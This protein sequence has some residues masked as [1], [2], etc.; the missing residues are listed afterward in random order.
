MDN[1]A[2]LAPFEEIAIIGMTGRFPLARNVDELWRNLRDGVESVVQFTD[3]ELLAAGVDPAL[4]GDPNYV[5]AGT[6][7]EGPDLFDAAFFGFNPRETEI[8]DPQQRLFLECAHESLELAGYDPQ[9]YRGLIGVF[10]GASASSYLANNLNKNPGVL[11]SVSP[12]QVLI[13]TDKDFVP[14]RV[15]YKLNLRGPS[16]N[17]QTACST[18]LVAVHLACQSLLERACDIALAG[19]VSIHFPLRAGYSYEEEGILSPDGHCRAFDIQARGCVGGNGVAIVVLKRLSEA[20]ADGDRILASIKGSAINNDGS[21]K[22]GYTAPSVQ[23]QAEAIASAQ[24]MAGVDPADITYIETH[25]TGTHLGDPL[26]IAALAQA[27]K[28]SSLVS[29]NSCAIG[30]VKT[31]VG[32]MDAAAGATGVIKTVL[33]LQHRQL[34]PSLNFEQPNPKLD[35]GNTPFC[36]NATLQEWKSERGPRLA[37]VSSF[38]LGGTN[39]HAI[40]EEAPEPTPSGASRPLQLVTI[41]AK[42]TAALQ[43]ATANLAAHLAAHPDSNLADVAFTQHVGRTAFGQR[44]VAVCEGVADA[45]AVLRGDHPERLWSYFDAPNERQVVFMFPG[46]GAQYP[47][48]GRGLYEQEAVYRDAIDRCALL[49]H[50]PL[51]L[52]LREIL[53]PPAERLE[54]ATSRLRQT[55]CGLP[56]L[57]TT[58]YA[59][60]ML[61]MSWGIRPDAMIGHSLGEYVAACLAGVFTLED[62]VTLVEARSRLMQTLPGGAMTVVPLPESELGEMLGSDLAIAAINGPALCLVSGKREAIEEF[63]RVLAGRGGEARRLH[64]DVASHCSLVAPMLGEFKQII[65]GLRRGLPQI[66]FISNVTGTWAGNEVSTPDYWA[67]HLRGTVRFADGLSELLKRKNL[68][69]LEVGPGNT[70]SM[71]ANQH[72]SKTGEH[73]VLS[74]QRHPRDSQSDFRFLMSSLGQLWLGGTKVDWGAFH[75]GERRHRVILPTYPFERRSYWVKPDKESSKRTRARSGRRPNLADCFYVPA[76]KQQLTVRPRVAKNADP[77]SWLVFADEFGLADGLITALRRDGQKVVR[78]RMGE[79]FKATSTGEFVIHAAEAAHYERLLEEL[80]QTSGMPNTIVHMWSLWDCHSSHKATIDQV[81]ERG[82]YSQLF[83]TQA[84][85]NQSTREPVNIAVIT[86]NA[87][88]VS[89]ERT[90]HPE[91][92]TVLGLCRII[93]QEYPNLKAYNLDID[94]SFLTEASRELTVRELLDWCRCGGEHPLTA[95]RGKDAW[96]PEFQPVQLEATRD[97]L[98]REKGVY[99][100]TGGLGGIALEIAEYLARSLAAKL[101]LVGRSAFPS[102][103]GWRNWLETHDQ[104]DETSRRIRILERIRE[105]GSELLVLSADV[106]DRARM[107]EVMTAAEER[108]GSINGAIHCA[109]V[110]G[111]GLIQLKA[112]ESAAAVLRP[113]VHGTL[114]LAE[115]LSEKKVDFLALCSSLAAVAGGVGHVDYCAANSFMDTFAQSRRHERGLPIISINWNAWQGVG[116]AASVNLPK[117]LQKW[118]QEIHSKGITAAEGTEALVRILGAGF[119]QVAVSTEDLGALIEEHYTYTPPAEDTLPETQSRSA[120]GRPNLGVAYAA[121]R[122]DVER[123]ITDLWQRFLGISEIGIHDNFFLLGGHSLLGTRLISRLRDTFDVDIPLRRLFEAPT[124]AGLAEAVAKQRLEREE[125]DTRQLLAKLE[126]LDEHQVEEELKK[127]ASNSTNGQRE[128]SRTASPSL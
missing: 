5:K 14:T 72:P 46:G 123:E 10:A 51:G 112:R 88:R 8:T 95:L 19:G 63:E 128:K 21:L 23:G 99:L 110:P 22:I 25:G 116:M 124:I 87:Q 33:Q 49:F 77:E 69:L 41:S 91:Q 32:H 117:D 92:A 66:P 119:P 108:F 100:I 105:H 28:A 62:A 120:H 106:A 73:M 13:G 74:S 54:E 67:Q 55:G 53:Y 70:L 97:T 18:S 47:K 57:F 82:F 30:S 4:L 111:G 61:W 17:V 103:D 38:G 101:I 122:N 90:L 86:S 64:I 11:E 26:E 7:L 6:V 78:V 37:G 42:T 125:Q 84:L 24:A 12:L 65:S 118:Q 126:A 29:S 20:L 2:T 115:L 76:W 35:L 39:A 3:E 81:L 83:L 34:V 96:I 60:A 85:G 113:K 107:Q 1:P 43:V 104:D 31:N 71:L 16:V 56:A 58:E 98:L 68:V 48:M 80:R 93:P 15:S 44:R 45:I 59:Q 79:N 94:A 89:N 127:L 27:F 102:P 36:V 121:P 109:G 9:T 114:V 40:L 52:D 50:R 75:K